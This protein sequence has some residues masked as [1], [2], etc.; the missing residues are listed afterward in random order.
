MNDKGYRVAILGGTGFAGQNVRNE[1]VAAGM[2]VEIFSR[3]TG[4]DIL[5]LP[6]AQTKLNAFCPT[7]V[8]NCAAHVGSVKYVTDFAADVVDENLRM[9]LNIYKIIHQMRQAIVINPIA[10]C[11]YPGLLDLYEESRFWDGPIHPSV[12]SYGSTRRMIEVLSGCYRAQYGV[13]SAN[14]F[15]PNMYGP[16]DSTDPGKTHALN[17]LV[18]KFVRASKM[19]AA[20]VEVWGSGKPIREWLFVKDFARVVRRLVEKNEELLNPVNIAQNYGLSVDE[21]V[22]IIC[23]KVQYKGRVVKNTKYPDGAPKKVMDDRLFRQRF[24]DFR[25]T[26]LE[27]GLTATIEYYQTIL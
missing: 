14:V 11:A 22:G 12:L 26:S 8:V 15:V 7:H 6:M 16:F 21:L 9:L 10:N 5:N 24:S 20:E 23:A 27:Q 25:F 1:L 13:R 18:I 2:V 3:S 4:C 19:G 17:A